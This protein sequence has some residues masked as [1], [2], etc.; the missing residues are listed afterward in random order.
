MP[1]Y[2]VN[3]KTYNIPEEKEKDFLLAYPKAELKSPLKNFQEDTIEGP[4]EVSDTTGS[5]SED[6]SSGSLSTEEPSVSVPEIE[7]QAGT[8]EF[9]DFYKT[10]SSIVYTKGVEKS[11]SNALNDFHDGY[12]GLAFEHT[13]LGDGLF[14]GN[15]ILVKSDYLLNRKQKIKLPKPTDSEAKW[16]RAYKKY[17]MIAE[18]HNEGVSTRQKILRKKKK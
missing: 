15:K 6:T 5:T 13:G 14:L 17:K 11:M 2:Y 3:G 12:G 9:D 18:L 8:M 7:I 4:T 10:A 1:K 16:K